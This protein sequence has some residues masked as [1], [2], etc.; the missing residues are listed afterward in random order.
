VPK[1]ELGAKLSASS[2]ERTRHAPDWS[3][4]PEALD[5]ARRAIEDEI[6]ELETQASKL[7][8][9]LARLAQQDHRRPK[10]KPPRRSAKR[11]PRG[12]R[13]RQLL[14]SIE[15]HPEYKPSEHAKAMKVSPKQIYPL[16][17]KLQGEGK[18]AK[19]AKGTYRIKK[20][21]SKAA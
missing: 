13:Q 4:M 10:A 11:A 1:K 6:H 21:R 15:Q 17:S 20:P 16:A 8:D 5:R 19:T 12:E 7:R 3:S 2:M 18:I 14:A 9:A